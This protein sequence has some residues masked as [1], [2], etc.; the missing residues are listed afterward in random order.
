MNNFKYYG[1]CSQD[2][3]LIE[4]EFLNN[5]NLKLYLY[6]VNNTYLFNHVTLYYKFAE[7][8]F[9]NSNHNGAQAEIYDKVFI[10]ASLSH[11]FVC[12]KGIRIDLGN[13]VLLIQNLRIEPFFNQRDSY[14]FDK[15]I[16]CEQDNPPMDAASMYSIWLTVFIFG[17]IVICF[18]LFI[19]FRVSS[20][21]STS[22]R[23]TPHDYSSL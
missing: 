12:K 21:D 19:V 16:I 9:P 23:K 13:V 4:F 7:P 17:I 8:L 11:S 14:E 5:W 1:T 20:D 2:Q 10:N 15:A 18:V 3:N 22:K 6:K